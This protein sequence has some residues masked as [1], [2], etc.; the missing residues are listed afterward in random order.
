MGVEIGFDA[1]VPGVITIGAA[2]CVLAD[3]LPVGELG[4]TGVV[5]VGTGVWAE[6][7]GFL[8]GNYRFA[9]NQISGT[10]Q[11]Q[12]LEGADCGSATTYFATLGSG[13]YDVGLLAATRYF[14]FFFAGGVVDSEMALQV[15]PIP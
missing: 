7:T 2:S 15:T 1:E 10:G 6:L 3:L 11:L 13:N 9:F 4:E 8:D 5:P 14:L 12:V